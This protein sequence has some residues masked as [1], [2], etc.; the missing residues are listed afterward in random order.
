MDSISGGTETKFEKSKIQK[1]EKID[2][3]G[4]SCTFRTFGHF[5]FSGFSGSFRTFWAFRLFVFFWHVSD[6][7]A[8]ST[9]WLFE[10]S[11]TF[12]DFLGFSAF[13][14]F[15]FSGFAALF[16]L[17][18]LFDFSRCLVLFGLLRFSTFLALFGRYVFFDV[19]GS[20][21]RFVFFFSRFWTFRLFS[22]LLSF[23]VVQFFDWA[24]AD[25]IV[26]RSFLESVIVSSVVVVAR[27]GLPALAD[28]GFFSF[29][30]PDAP[31]SNTTDPCRW[32][33]DC[34]RAHVESGLLCGSH[35]VIV[36]LRSSM[37]MLSL[38]RFYRKAGRTTK[39]NSRFSIWRLKGRYR[40]S[41]IFQRAWVLKRACGVCSCQ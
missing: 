18:G 40:L 10:F 35:S 1:V 39:Q 27:S 14:L 15:D 34:Q 37:P 28:G 11:G 3:S 22:C 5:D 23:L 26:K 12:S 17:V 29:P 30:K 38:H 31:L 2:F 8:F 20:A 36:A 21:V 16:G 32:G 7:E 9:F 33:I 24:L 25:K 19:S 4:F 6:F 41:L 13:R